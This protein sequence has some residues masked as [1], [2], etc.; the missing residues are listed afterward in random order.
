MGKALTLNPLVSLR[1]GSTSIHFYVLNTLPF[2]I[3]NR[4]RS[5]V[6]F[7]LW[8]FISF[9]CGYSRVSADYTVEIVT[10]SL[11][12]S[13]GLTLSWQCPVFSCKISPTYSPTYSKPFYEDRIS[14]IHLTFR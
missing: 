1:H 12:T 8:H 9:S 4:F 10:R 6:I 3:Y 5:M 13:L 14:F 11:R 2:V 7:P